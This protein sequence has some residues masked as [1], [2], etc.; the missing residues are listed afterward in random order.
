MRNTGW[1]KLQPCIGYT[2]Y[3]TDFIRPSCGECGAPMILRTSDKYPNKDGSPRKFYGCTRWPVCS[4][5]H[6]AHQNSGKPMGIPADKETKL[7]RQQAHAL[8]DPYVKKW[9]QNRR[10]G[11]QF[12]ANVMG[13]SEKDAH[14]SRFNIDQC[15]KL[16]TL[17]ENS[18]KQ[19]EA[20]NRE[21]LM[22]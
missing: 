13:L 18:N 16:I 14:I 10:E 11:Y 20:E 22:K 3:M 5:T 12:L 1:G 17:L 21:E 6:S 15:K 4:G 9:F 8:F 19:Y 2:K 7:A